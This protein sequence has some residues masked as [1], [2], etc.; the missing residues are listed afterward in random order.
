MARSVESTPMAAARCIGPES[1]HTKT[2][3]RE[4]TAE[5]ARTLYLQNQ[6]PAFALIS[7]LPAAVVYFGVRE[8]VSRTRPD[9]SAPA[10]QVTTGPAPVAELRGD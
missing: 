8:A 1:G 9:I 7:F 6:L 5:A 3:Q 4:A 10:E 2:S